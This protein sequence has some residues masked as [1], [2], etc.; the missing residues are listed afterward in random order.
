MVLGLAATLHGVQLRPLSASQRAFVQQRRCFLV[1]GLERVRRL[2]EAAKER[3]RLAHLKQQQQQQSSRS[4]RF[5]QK[6]EA[7]PVPQSVESIDRL[8]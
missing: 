1:R 7:A 2:R 8:H 4:R 5:L 6:M 3:L